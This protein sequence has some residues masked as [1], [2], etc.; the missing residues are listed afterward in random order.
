V[1]NNTITNATQN[2]VKFILQ[3]GPAETDVSVYRAIAHTMSL[4]KCYS[5]AMQLL[6]CRVIAVLAKGSKDAREMIAA[7]IPAA[8]VAAMSQQSA[9]TTLTLQFWCCKVIHILADMP[10]DMIAH[11]GSVGACEALVR[12]MIGIPGSIGIAEWACVA[13]SKLAFGNTANRNRLC[14]AGAYKAVVYALRVHSDRAA[15]V[16]R[17]CAAI[18]AIARKSSA[19]TSKLAEQGACSAVVQDMT[20][21]VDSAATVSSACMAVSALACNDAN[22]ATFATRAVVT[23]I[24]TALRQHSTDKALV[25]RACMTYSLLASRM[26]AVMKRSCTE[27]LQEMQLLHRTDTET[28]NNL[29]QALTRLSVH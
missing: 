24:V 2:K 23:A 21:H 14:A 26:T 12:A 10:G 15:T 8:V 27:V 4:Y 3:C 1:H 22:R 13:V 11:L 28:T 29:Q 7:G 9:S 25:R 17:A 19:Y 16:E 6:A 20:Q 18:C 5:R